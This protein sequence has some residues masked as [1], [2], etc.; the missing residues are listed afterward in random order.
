MGAE[1]KRPEKFFV[2]TYPNLLCKTEQ[3]GLLFS[4]WLP[5]LQLYLNSIHCSIKTDV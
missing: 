5:V 1:M 4:F 3:R 2:V